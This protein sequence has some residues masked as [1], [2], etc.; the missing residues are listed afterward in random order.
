MSTMGYLHEV[1]ADALGGSPGWGELTATPAVSDIIAPMAPEL[2]APSGLPSA[3]ERSAERFERQRKTTAP[4][5]SWG[6][7]LQDAE[8]P[9]EALVATPRTEGTG[10]ERTGDDGGH[11]RAGA[12]RNS[13]TTSLE[14]AC[15]PFTRSVLSTSSEAYRSGSR[16]VVSPRAEVPGADGSSFEAKTAEPLAVAGNDLRR[17]EESERA[18][19]P[20]PDHG[21]THQISWPPLEDASPSVVPTSHGNEPQTRELART[22]ALLP[23][24]GNSS[25]ESASAT[26]P[27]VLEA[28]ASATAAP[29]SPAGQGQVAAVP[30]EIKESL[31]GEPVPDRIPV[32]PLPT[33]AEAPRLV[34]CIKPSEGTQEL[35]P[36]PNTPFST[37]TFLHVVHTVARLEPLLRREAGRVPETVAASTPRMH[38][39]TLE[40][41]VTAPTP[42]SAP[43]PPPSDFASRRYL[44]RF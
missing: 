6:T 32:R 8:L 12:L 26:P 39:G 3:Q 29:L 14:S 22:A 16:V 11:S 9:G 41:V 10:G 20:D 37:D 19:Q 44:R 34:G 23:I 27:H 35:P 17:G 25:V 43:P 42:P 2:S 36:H 5:D 30:S 33:Q 4:G 15:V 1:V 18:S 40:I 7:A 38:I 21:R 28:A 31:G 24:A 13:E